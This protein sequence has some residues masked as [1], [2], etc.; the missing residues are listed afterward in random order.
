MAEKRTSL[1]EEEKAMIPVWIEKYTKIARSTEPANFPLAI[2]G[3]QMHYEE[4]R[5]EN[6]A[7][8]IPS[9]FPTAPSPVVAS[10][11]IGL[12][13]YAIDKIDGGANRRDSKAFTKAIHTIADHKI[14]A[15]LA[16]N[17]C[18]IVVDALYTLYKGKYPTAN[19][20]GMKSTVRENW[21]KYLGGQAW[22]SFVA[23]ATFYRDVMKIPNIPIEARE[24]TDCNAGWWWPHPKLAVITDRPSLLS[25]DSRNRL[26]GTIGAAIEWRDG[27]KQYFWHGIR[28]AEPWII[29]EPE[30][31]TVQHIR[32]QNNAE[33]RRAC[34]EFYNNVHGDGAYL[35]DS[36]ARIIDNTT[37]EIG[38]L[39]EVDLGEG[40]T[41]LFAMVVNSTKL[42]PS[43]DGISRTDGLLE[44][45][46]PG[47]NEES[48][49]DVM[50]GKP[51]GEMDDSKSGLKLQPFEPEHKMY[52]LEVFQNNPADG[53]PVRTVKQAVAASF[54]ATE[55]EY[56]SELREQS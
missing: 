28:I 11:A 39:Y 37:P 3:I 38:T 33:L 32:S 7:I 51:V 20:D 54:G 2:R 41:Q 8:E 47:D 24:L 27:F 4:A 53:T 46:N 19:I 16:D 36:K 34:I 5:K 22:V 25:F 56:W 35:I 30:R 40:A 44:R 26:H 52:Q 55:K 29:E 31:L 23:R 42:P 45:A 6:S 49:Y 48:L 15:D 9:L 1:T 21:A 12:L 18:A 50:P 17:V 10:Y 13:C 43:N 14:G